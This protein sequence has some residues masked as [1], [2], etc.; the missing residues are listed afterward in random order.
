MTNEEVLEFVKEWLNER[1]IK[2]FFEDKNNNKDTYVKI[3][4]QDLYNLCYKII[5]LI[6]SNIE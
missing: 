6:E 2:S 4:K 1:K 3:K 5:A